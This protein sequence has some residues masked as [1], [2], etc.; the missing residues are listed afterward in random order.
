MLNIEQKKN[1]IIEFE[2]EWLFNDASP[3]DC[4][5]ILK[6]GWKGWDNMPNKAIEEKYKDLTED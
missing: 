3:K 4:A 1:F 2:T 6:H 5:D